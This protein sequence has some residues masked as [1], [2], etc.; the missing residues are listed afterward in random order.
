M[1]EHQVFNDLTQDKFESN[2]L[3]YGNQNRKQ[4]K[5]SIISSQ[6]NLY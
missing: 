6:Y 3:Y 4:Q 5:E 2:V 1:G